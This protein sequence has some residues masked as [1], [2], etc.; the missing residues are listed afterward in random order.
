MNWKPVSPDHAIDV[1][2]LI[3]KADPAAAHALVEQR[4]PCNKALGDHPSVQVAQKDESL[5]VGLLGVLNGIFRADEDGWGTICAVFEDDGTLTRFERTKRTLKNPMFRVGGDEC[6]EFLEANEALY[7]DGFEDAFIGMVYRFGISGPVA[8]YDQDRCIQ[9]LMDR[10]GMDYEGAIE[11]FEFNTL[12]AWV[13]EGT[14][15]FARLVAPD[16]PAAEGTA[17]T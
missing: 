7:A 1:L 15:A 4:V 2:N 6:A 13:G 16:G 10:D 12:G 11:C 3:L 17:R 14:P 8:L 9:I 5:T